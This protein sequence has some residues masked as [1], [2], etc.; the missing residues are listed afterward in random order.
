VV[1]PLALGVW[2]AAY[3]EVGEVRRLRSEED[4]R[5][6][7]SALFL[8]E[9][10][11]QRS[12]RELAP[13]GRELPGA[14]RTLPGVQAALAGDTVPLLIPGQDGLEL[15]VLLPW[16]DDGVALAS[17][18]FDPRFPGA[19][20]ESVAYDVALYQ[21]RVRRYS[22]RADFGPDTLSFGLNRTIALYPEGMP[23]RLVDG[24]GSLHARSARAG[25]APDMVMLV[26][27]FEPGADQ[28]SRSLLLTLALLASGFGVAGW[29][30]LEVRPPSGERD[31]LRGKRTLI[32][33][34]IPLA[35]ALGG[36]LQLARGFP[37][38]ARR[39]TGLELARGLALAGREWSTL[40]PASARA[41][42]GFHVTVFDGDA[43]FASTLPP[44]ASRLQEGMAA[45]EFHAEG[46]GGEGRGG[47]ELLHARARMA[48]G[49]T[50]VLTAA[51]PAVR[52]RGLGYRLA[53]L[54]GSMLFLAL[55]FP[56]L[57]GEERLRRLA[58]RQAS[59]IGGR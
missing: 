23:L 46:V 26:S 33:V 19:V 12:V 1:L 2:A 4:Q 3:L 45:I 48:D 22:S 36:L 9:R 54:G 15:H 51:G 53:A 47:D 25:E 10:D 8:L 37:V 50:L 58:R 39:S 18:P 13:L 32:L 52:L 57:R 20:A 27:P 59:T 42:T 34:W 24:W 17:G 29:W 31:P 11:L 16:R 14:D 40:T 55:L 56:L 28:V 38:E 21:G 7:T 6:G 35:L 43:L 49:R 30:L 41:L 44:G 5:V